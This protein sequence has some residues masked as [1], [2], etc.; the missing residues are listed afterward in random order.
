MG[1]A[2]LVGVAVLGKA[3]LVD[4]GGGALAP[5]QG[6]ESGR[7]QVGEQRR[8]P[9]AA[10]EPDQHAAVVADE[11]AQLGDNPAQ[12]T[13]SEAAGWAITTKSGSPAASDTQV[14]TVA[15]AGNFSR[16]TWVLAILRVP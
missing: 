4:V 15:G 9:A 14:S 16:G 8:G 1:A 6:V 13:A 11:R 10:V 7:I 2:V 3:H 5:G 12:L